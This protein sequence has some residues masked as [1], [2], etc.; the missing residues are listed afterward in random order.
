MAPQIRKNMQ[1]ACFFYFSTENSQAGLQWF[2]CSL[3]TALW[4]HYVGLISCLLP[5]TYRAQPLQCSNCFKSEFKLAPGII[6]KIL[7]HQAFHS[8]QWIYSVGFCVIQ[9]RWFLRQIIIVGKRLE[10]SLRHTGPIFVQWYFY[11]TY[12]MFFVSL[13]VL[14]NYS[15]TAWSI[16][17]LLE[18]SVVDLTT[19][20]ENWATSSPDH[21]TFL[22]F[23]QISKGL[24][25]VATLDTHPKF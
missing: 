17:L 21:V 4:R 15:L 19:C 9:G 18:F 2:L 16:G 20:H 10:D 5:T 6:T 11:Q 8:K 24:P 13:W 7:Q 23:W 22:S 12:N 3:I 1:C 14:V 25:T